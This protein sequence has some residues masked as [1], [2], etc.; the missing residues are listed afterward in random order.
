[1]RLLQFLREVYQDAPSVK[2]I[3][4]AIDG[5]LCT[6]N[7]RIEN[8]SSYILEENDLVAL[9]SA[10]TEKTEAPKEIKFSILYEDP[11]Y[12]IINKPAGIV[13]DTR[14]IR[15][16]LPEYKEALE[17][18]HR[19][20]KETSGA[21]ILAKSAEAK[22]KMITLFTDHK[23]KKLYLALVDGV[24]AK[25]AG[26]VDN[27]L[28]K[29]HSYDGQTIYGTVSE[30]KGQR[31]ITHWKCVK[32]GKTAS[33]IYCEPFTGRTHQLRVHLSTMGHPILGDIQYGKKFTCAFKPQR[34][35]LHAYRIDFKHPTT[36][37]PIQVTAPIPHD[38]KLALAA[39]KID[40]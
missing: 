23:L 18:V 30:N 39:L 15:S 26:T 27:H 2:A 9:R 10:L 8:F 25:E 34:N 29:K 33:V 4:R 11:E 35:L 40:L 5:K 17:L 1:M 36:G 16:H 13:S 6:V 20:D 14:S 24:V 38:F 19:L 21:L 7:R 31:A 3:K 28:G 22:E 12:L 32:R 37:K